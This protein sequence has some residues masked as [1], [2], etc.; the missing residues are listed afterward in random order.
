MAR[1]K[2]AKQVKASTKESKIENLSQAHGQEEKFEPTTLSQ[3][4]GDDGVSKYKTL[5]ETE[6]ATQLAEMSRTDLHAHASQI[7]LIPVENVEQLKKRL[8]AEFKR[9][10]AQYRKPSFDKKSALKISDEATKILGEG[11]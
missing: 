11:R 6:Y 8:V 10:V 7:G 9:H 1:K 5:D 2:T 4:W 3:I